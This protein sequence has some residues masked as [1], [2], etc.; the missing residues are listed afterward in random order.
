MST[1]RIPTRDVQ[2][3]DTVMFLGHPHV[4]AHIEPYNH[5]TVPG[6]L[7]ILRAH[8]GWGISFWPHDMIDVAQVTA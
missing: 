5:P 3:G 6:S 8:D 1:Q 7:G 4:I 2:P